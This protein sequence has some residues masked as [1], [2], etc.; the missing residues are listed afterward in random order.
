[1]GEGLSA[2]ETPVDPDWKPNGMDV[3]CIPSLNSEGN[4]LAQN[5]EV[6]PEIIDLM[7]LDILELELACK[8]KEF[9]KIPDQQLDRLEVIISRAFQQKELGIQRGNRW[10]GSQSN[11]D[12]KK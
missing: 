12:S 9:D 2:D 4:C 7:G 11:K 6:E 5:M 1:M 10:D 8:R 3:D